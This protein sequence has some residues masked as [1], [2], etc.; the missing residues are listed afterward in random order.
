MRITIPTTGSRG[1]VEPY[2][3]LGVGLRAHGHEVC[4]AT[5]ADFEAFIRGHGLNFHSLEEGGQALQANDTGDRMLN[6]G[7]NPFAFL[8]EFTRQ[9]PAVASQAAA[10]LLARLL[11]GRRDPLHEHRVPAGRGGRRA[12]TTARGLGFAHA[13]GAEP[14][15]SELPVPPV[16]PLVARLMRV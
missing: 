12:G 8:S 14:I 1:D 3:A 6:A 16:S 15:P 13:L 7:S 10:P 5:H 4:L 11:R 9:A 2:V